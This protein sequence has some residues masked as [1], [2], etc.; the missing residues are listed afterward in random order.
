MISIIMPTYNE[1]GN[2]KELILRVEKELKKD[3]E[4]IV[5]DD[6]SEDGT[7]KIVSDLKKDNKYLRL[8]TRK[9]ERGLPS[10]I[11]RGIEEARGV[12]VSWFD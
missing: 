11:K 9:R 6:D 12:I 8:I 2:I 1:A 5:V 4:I 7:G 3:F 10:A